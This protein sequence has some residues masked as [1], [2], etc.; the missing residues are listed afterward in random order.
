MKL[1]KYK[2]ICILTVL[3]FLLMP[4]TAYAVSPP[5]GYATTSDSNLMASL[6]EYID[7]YPEGMEKGATGYGQNREGYRLEQRR[8]ILPKAA[9]S[10]LTV[11]WCEYRERGWG[12]GVNYITIDF[13]KTESVSEFP[14]I[15]VTLYY[16][17]AD[18][19]DV[20]K[21]A[22]FWE[23][24][25]AQISAEDE[26]VYNGMPYYAK[27]YTLQN[28][29]KYCIY[30]MVKGNILINVVDYEPFSKERIGLIKYEETD[31]FLPVFVEEQNQPKP[32]EPST[33]T[34]KQINW[35]ILIYCGTVVM[36]IG[37]A[38]WLVRKR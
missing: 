6:K 30:N 9:D 31:L 21:T 22:L 20:Y 7:G 25:D 37:L 11:Q 34:G 23:R 1:M 8:V 26:G 14:D 19:S 17:Y 4:L 15:R 12:D 27:T 10:G 13:I 32:N 36:L 3:L 35:R 33:E 5:Y 29:D 38:V 28:G 2:I 24:E 16:D 18:P